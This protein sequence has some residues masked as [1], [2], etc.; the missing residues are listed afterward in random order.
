[1]STAVAAVMSGAAMVMY[2][3]R[4]WLLVEHISSVLTLILLHRIALAEHV[5][6]TRIRAS[7]G[8]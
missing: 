6:P 5:E 2:L 1:M 3:F 4:R 7:H 8:H